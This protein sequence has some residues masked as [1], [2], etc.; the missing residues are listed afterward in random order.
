M[1]LELRQIEF[2]PLSYGDWSGRVFSWEG[3]VYRAITKERAEFYR[4]ILSEGI[5]R[6]LAQRNLIIDTET[7]EWEIVGY[8][9][10][11]KHRTVP[12]VSYCHEWCGEMLKTA[13]LSVLEL[14]KE[15]LGYGLTL[16]D[17]HPCNV[18][19]DGPA[20]IWVD[21]GSLAPLHLGERWGSDEQ[22]SAY[23]TRPLKI[24]AAGHLH[25][26]RCLLQDLYFCGVGQRDVEALTRPASAQI[27]QTAKKRA[28]SVARRTVPPPV[29]PL[30]RRLV[31]DFRHQKPTQ[32]PDGQ[33][34]V[35]QRI[36]EI[37]NIRLVQPQTMW[38]TYDVTMGFPDFAAP[39]D[40]NQK[41]HSLQQILSAKKPKS[42]LDIGSNRGWYSQL[43]ARNGAQVV[44]VDFDETSVT[45]LFFD[46]LKAKLPILPLVGDFRKLSP[47]AGLVSTS[48]IAPTERLRCDMVLAL[49]LVHNLVSM[50]YLDFEQIVRGMSMFARRWLVIE[51]ADRK[52]PY[53]RE[54]VNEFPCY[55]LNNFLTELDKEFGKIEL[56]PSN[57]E[58]R[59]LLLCER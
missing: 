1:K 52:D 12:F 26:A 32:E 3:N 43:A 20:P 17:V 5:I 40:W 38:S 4:H 47:M 44:S 48:N 31:K 24:M 34:N 58:H 36:R 53:V 10:V 22:F 2:H 14:K 18:L 19:F 35:E 51:F 46:T 50:F 42:V 54:W 55:S 11:L 9:L 37:E 30:V 56:L 6:K 39:A 41:H 7:T 27:I 16:Q 15:L 25:I 57:V 28:K 8:A 13:A 21:L 49:A 45:N 29:R 59:Q 33:V 23:Y